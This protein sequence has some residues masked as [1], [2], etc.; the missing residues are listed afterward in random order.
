L[1]RRAM[2]SARS[3]VTKSFTCSGDIPSV[4]NVIRTTP[5]SA[6]TSITDRGYSS[7]K[8]AQAIDTVRPPRVD[9]K[10]FLPC[11]LRH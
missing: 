11:C 10:L 6:D 3:Q 5:W 9:L 2:P 4:E 8:D 7:R 1:L